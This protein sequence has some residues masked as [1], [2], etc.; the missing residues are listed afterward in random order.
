VH[1]PGAVFIQLGHEQFEYQHDQR[2]TDSSRRD[3]YFTAGDIG[4][5]DEEGYLFLCGRSADVIISGGVNIYP[6]QIESVLAVHPAVGDVAVIG[7]PD[8][9]W[10]EQ[11][12][13]IVTVRAGCR[14]DAALVDE[15]KL[16]CRHHLAGLKC[17]KTIDFVAEMPRGEN[18][19]LYKEGLRAA[20]A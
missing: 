4:Y 16:H 18:G 5:L 15:L 7:V 9:E 8:A 20:Y 14:A 13:A 3:G 1:E 12:K 2:K 6:A 17:P 10:G 11:V 19:K